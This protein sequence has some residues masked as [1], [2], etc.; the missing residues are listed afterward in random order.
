MLFLAC[1]TP[2]VKP[3]IPYSFLVAGHVYGKPGVDNKG[4]HLPFQSHFENFKNNSHLDFAVF[5][6]D[7]V[8]KSNKKNYVELDSVVKTLPFPVHYMPGNHELRNEKLYRKRYYKKHYYFQ[9]HKDLFLLLD[10]NAPNWK[11]DPKQYQIIDTTQLPR[12]IF[13]FVHQVIWHKSFQKK[14]IPNSY[15]GYKNG[16][17]FDQAVLPYFKE[18]NIP[19]YF[20][21][22]DVGAGK[23]SNGISYIKE[24]ENLHFIASGMGNE[25]NDNFL[26]VIVNKNKVNI[27]VHPLEAGFTQPTKIDVFLSK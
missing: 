22:G 15:E 17:S 8:I 11:I 6:G 5:A 12:N 26:E 4:V 24:G 2:Q 13:V 23:N 27:T 1:S 25:I 20:F 3:E 18:L 7:M 21:A 16:D 9:H 10:A 14:V 19:V